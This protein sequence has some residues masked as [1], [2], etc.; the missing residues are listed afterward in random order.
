[1]SLTAEGEVD[2]LVQN[3]SR[4]RTIVQAHRYYKIGGL[5]DVESVPTVERPDER[6]IDKAFKDWLAL[7]D[8]P[9]PKNV[10]RKGKQ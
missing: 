10:T 8:G 1:M 2:I 7:G 9:K 4:V 3:T 5:S 6:K